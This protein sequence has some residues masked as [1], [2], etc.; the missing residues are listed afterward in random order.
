MLQ[1]IAGSGTVPLEMKRAPASFAEKVRMLR[2]ARGV[3]QRSLAQRIQATSQYLSRVE[4]GL[5]SPGGQVLVALARELGSSVEAMMDPAIS[6]ADFLHT[7]MSEKRGEQL[8]AGDVPREI[9]DLP[10][11]FLAAFAL[12]L[13]EGGTT[14]LTLSGYPHTGETYA[15]VVKDGEVIY[16]GPERRK[17][18][19]GGRRAGGAAA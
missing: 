3:S 10:G 13:R 11:E 14:S 1:I 9:L 7:A 2:E 15:V 12:A 16:Q 18:S 5:A 6:V 19:L 8:S 4:R 17:Q